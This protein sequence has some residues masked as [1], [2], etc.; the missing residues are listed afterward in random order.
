MSEKGHFSILS[1]FW[2]RDCIQRRGKAVHTQKKNKPLLK[3][4]LR[5][6]GIQC[7]KQHQQEALRWIFK[8]D[9]ALLEVPMLLFCMKVFELK[10]RK[11]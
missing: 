10:T 1:Y 8:Q 7:L 11:T 3:L 4:A 2:M 5:T 6:G 9:H